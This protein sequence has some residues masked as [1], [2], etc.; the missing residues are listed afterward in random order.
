MMI[1]PQHGILLYQFFFYYV[2]IKK[3]EVVHRNSHDTFPFRKFLFYYAYVSYVAYVLFSR[4]ILSDYY[5]DLVVEARKRNIQTDK[6]S[7]EL[8][9]YIIYLFFFK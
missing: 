5:I 9:F 1:F 6:V 4:F 2:Y 8:L 7:F 3:S